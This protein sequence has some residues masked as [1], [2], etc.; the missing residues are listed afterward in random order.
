[1]GVKGAPGETRECA[2]D[3]G[4]FS[5]SPKKVLF[6]WRTQKNPQFISIVPYIVWPTLFNNFLQITLGNFFVLRKLQK[7]QKGFYFFDFLH[8]IIVTIDLNKQYFILI[9]QAK[10]VN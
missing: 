9:G 7:H 2:I 1:M 4:P 10:S 6:L 8:F 3:I 5:T